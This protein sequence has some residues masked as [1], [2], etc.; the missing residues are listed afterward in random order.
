M[1][2]T[3]KPTIPIEEP[4]IDTIVNTTVKPK[5]D[6]TLAIYIIIAVILLVVIF[7][8]NAYAVVTM[9]SRTITMFR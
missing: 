2:P 8:I 7:T 3:G 5:D 1:I 6:S 9:I 4:T